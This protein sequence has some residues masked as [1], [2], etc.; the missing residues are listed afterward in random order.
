MRNSRTARLSVFGAAALGGC[1]HSPFIAEREPYIR[2]LV[3]FTE[4]FKA[5][6]R[7]VDLKDS[8]NDE[9]CGSQ[10]RAYRRA[11]VQRA[12]VPEP[13][14]TETADLA[15]RRIWKEFE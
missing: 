4:A 12:T 1:V 10:E 7:S 9:Y 6:G 8:S 3:A 5:A 13:G 11:V 15:V 14:R 2:C